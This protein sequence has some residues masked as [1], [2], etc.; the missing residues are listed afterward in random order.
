MFLI[1]QQHLPC[2]LWV[3]MVDYEKKD[4]CSESWR[5]LHLSWWG[6]WH[7]CHPIITNWLLT[8]PQFQHLDI[9]LS[10]AR[11]LF[12]YPF[13]L[14]HWTHKTSV[15]CWLVPPWPRPDSQSADLWWFPHTHHLQEL[16]V[17]PYPSHRFRSLSQF[18]SSI[19]IHQYIPCGRKTFFRK[20]WAS[21]CSSSEED[22]HVRADVSSWLDHPAA[23]AGNWRELINPVTQLTRRGGVQKTYSSRADLLFKM[24]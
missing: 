21:A 17:I 24:C 18:Y 22:F 15:Y 23:A 1:Y 12:L 8:A 13:L 9:S 7:H 20:Q 16:K 3:G 11:L 6:W 5:R 14:L 4:S 2:K 19:L 10:A